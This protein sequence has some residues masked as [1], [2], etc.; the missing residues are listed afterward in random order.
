MIAPGFSADESDWCIPALL[1][2]VRALSRAHEVRVF[3]LRY[4]P[5]RS[6]YV[7]HGARVNALGGGTAAG[8]GRLPLLAGA[9]RRIVAA[10]RRDPF[11]VLHGFWADEPGFLAVTAGRL[12]GVPSVVS[13]AGGE[14]V[15]FPDLGYGGQL[16]RVNRW[17]ADRCL[18]TA[19]RVTVGSGQL[20]RVVAERS[21]SSPLI[22]PFGVDTRRFSPTGLRGSDSPF[23]R[24]LH[25]GSLTPVKDQ[26]TLLRAFARVAGKRPDIALDVAG[27]GP[28]REPLATLAERLGLGD[29]VR[30][31]G[32]VPHDRLP[33]LYR[34]ADLFVLSSRHESQ[35]LAALEAAACGTPVVGT[36]VGV[37]PELGSP[38]PAV[39]PGDAEG[40]GGPAAPRRRRGAPSRQRRR[41][42]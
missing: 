28:L 42:A 38:G 1:D 20:G 7:V 18:T 11:D 26:A 29:R 5:R 25:V 34:T 40:R 17:M 16:S 21:G 37:I 2:L 13:V 39:P 35:G 31:L 33:T 10:G 24:L 19:R 15:G 41:G 22:L 9:M 23:L 27:D 6:R 4:P 32:A 30:F 36:A 14:L 3:A 12:L 8:F